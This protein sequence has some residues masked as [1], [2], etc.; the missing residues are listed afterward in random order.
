MKTVA[1]MTMAFLPATFLAALFA[2]PVME[3]D[4]SVVVEVDGFVLYWII[5]VVLT[6]FVFGVWG[7]ITQRTWVMDKVGHWRRRRAQDTE[8]R[9]L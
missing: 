8:L 2:L 6:V 9:S 5:T 3:W 4:K 7:I 1:V